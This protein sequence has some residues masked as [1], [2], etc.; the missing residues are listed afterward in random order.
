MSGTRRAALTLHSL[1]ETDRQW[2]MDSLPSETSARLRSLL[3]EITELGLQPGTPGLVA[4]VDLSP[5]DPDSGSQAV[6][7]FEEIGAA[8]LAHVMQAEP[9]EVIEAVLTL[10]G[11][12]ART[13]VLS[14]IG[15]HRRIAAAARAPGHRTA[16]R[17]NASLRAAVE[18]QARQLPAVGPG[19]SEMF[20]GARERMARWIER[21]AAWK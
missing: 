5:P 1:S 12:P 13:D 21:V 4:Q 8:R 17:L 6:M 11:A 9:A 2:I 19:G 10:S 18:A 7:T 3:D 15:G 20:H 14:R 16:P